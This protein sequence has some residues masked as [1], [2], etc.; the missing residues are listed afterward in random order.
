MEP[1]VKVE[2]L[3]W[4]EKYRPSSIDECI[5]PTSVK[6]QAKGMV[7]SGNLNNLLLSGSAG[8][9][10]TTLAIAMCNMMNADWIMYNGSDGSLN[11]EAL[12]EDISEFAQTTSLKG[13]SQMKV[14]IIDE[15]DGL[16]AMVQGALRNA[17]EKYSKGCRFIITC[18]Y[19]DKIIE[20][21]HSRCAHIDYKFS[22][23]D[24]NDLVKQF[25]RR[26]VQILQDNQVSYDV[27]TLKE[28]IVKY[29]PDNRKIINELQRYANQNGCIDEGILRELKTNTDMLFDAILKKDFPSTK[30]WLEDYYTG[31]IFN[32]LYKEGENR[33]PP[34]LLP[35]W[36]IK[37]GEAQRYHGHVP[38]QAL[39]VLAALTS[40][41]AES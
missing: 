17:M 13:S 30:Q 35:L 5:L 12:R 8:T 31:S 26:C 1:N 18:N 34:E 25:A 36:I 33:I 4:T 24:L 3:L 14:V 16:S 38:N 6:E 41:M 19:P 9:G 27:E 15:G 21:L 23:E 2:Q 7:G 40:F 20:P 22:K 37:I 28:V 29:Y 39:N 32:I 10:K 11:I